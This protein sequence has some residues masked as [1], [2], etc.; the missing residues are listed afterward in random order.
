M[1]TFGARIQIVIEQSGLK[2][3]QFAEKMGISSAYVSQLCSDVRTPSD[4]LVADICR[5][6]KV[7]REWLENGEEPM[8]YPEPET[9]MDVINE[10][11]MDVDNPV[12]EL[13]RKIYRTYKKLPAEDQQTFQRFVSNLLAE[14]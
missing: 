3:I 9:D 2:K 8:R 10:L 7:R 12:A 5:E 13:I 6:F 4:R 11:L 14:Q 1:D